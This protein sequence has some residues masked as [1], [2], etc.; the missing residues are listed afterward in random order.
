MNICGTD[1]LRYASYN[2]NSQSVGKEGIRVDGEEE[3]MSIRHCFG[4]APGREWYSMDYENIELRIPA[5]ESGEEVMVKLFERPDEPP[6]WGSYHLMNAS[7]IFPDLFWPLADYPPGHELSFKEQYDGT[8]YK[9]TKGF[10]FAFS[11][12]GQKRTCDRAARRPG[13]WELVRSRLTEHSKLNQR[14]VD[15]A[16]RLGYVETLPDREVDPSRGYPVET[17]R[18]KYGRVSPTVPLNYHVQSTAMWCTM[19]AMV[20]CQRLLDRWTREDP[21]SGGYRMT[22]QVHDEIMF[23]F[24]AGRLGNSGKVEELR[25]AMERSGDDVGI[26]LRVTA[27]LH[28][29]SWDAGEKVQRTALGRPRQ[30]AGAGGGRYAGRGDRASGGTWQ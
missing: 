10:G 21:G 19:K 5:Y 16:N 7:I 13:S 17:P 29:V 2:P 28:R 8:W 22:M 27:K 14:Y 15:Q 26:P 12:G 18:S 9:C 24:P 6:F 20:R 30:L 23:D 25:R 3:A 4:P 11:Y 1:T